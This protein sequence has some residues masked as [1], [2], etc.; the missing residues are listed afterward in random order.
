MCGIGQSACLELGLRRVSGLRS[1][2]HQP[3]LPPVQR[4]RR[5]HEEDLNPHRLQP[6]QGAQPWLLRVLEEVSLQQ[7]EGIVQSQV[8]DGGVGPVRREGGA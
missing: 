8:E 2:R 3:A 7:A 6:L 1:S 5:R 4:Q